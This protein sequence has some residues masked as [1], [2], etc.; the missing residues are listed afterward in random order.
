V[1]L[2]N[3]PRQSL[4]DEVLQ[5]GAMTTDPAPSGLRV[6]VIDDDADQRLAVV[7]LFAQRGVRDV[8]QAASAAEGLNTAITQQP[9]L[10]VLDLSMPGRS[11]IDVLPDLHEAV[12]GA[13]IVVLSNMP[14]QSLLDE[15][16]QRGAMG[17]VEKSVAPSRL[18][19]EILVAAALTDAGRAGVLQLSASTTSPG[20]SRRLVREL[21]GDADRDLV[22]D[23]ELLVSE[24]VTNAIIHTST[25]P[26]L[27]VH[28]HRDLVRVAVYDADPNPPVER[29][30]PPRDLGGRGLRFVSELSSRWGSERSGD[31]KVVWLEIDR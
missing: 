20:Q 1:V 4:L 25:E 7:G 21:L 18:I 15:V 22:A 10:I 24:L 14:R 29:D 11:G 13:A 27:E 2:S 5:R 19:D 31:G 28:V 16:L 30:A 9:N 26:R 8:V 3:M 12:P 17:F 23:V 6:L